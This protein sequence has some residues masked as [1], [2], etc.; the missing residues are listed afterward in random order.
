[1]AS[2]RLNPCDTPPLRTDRRK[3]PLEGRPTR[4]GR[5]RKIV[6]AVGALALSLLGAQIVLAA[7]PSASITAPSLLQIG[8]VGTFTATTSDPDGG[9][10]T[11]IEWDFEDDGTFDKTGASVSH[12]YGTAGQKTVRLRVT[13]S[14]AEVT[15]ATATVTVNAPP[16]ARI[17]AEPTRAQIGQSVAFSGID[18]S[19]PDPGDSIQTYEWDLGTGSF[20]SPSASPNAPPTSFATG[21]DKNIRLRVTDKFG[22]AHVATL[23]FHVNLKPLAKFIFAAVNPPSGQTGVALDPGQNLQVPIIGQ[24]VAF[25][26][27]STDS[28]GTIKAHAWFD[29][30]IPGEGPTGLFTGPFAGN[31]ASPIHVPYTIAGNMR[32][33]LQVT[34]NEDA[35]SETNPPT[36]EAL[37]T[38]RVNTRPESDF[39][40]SPQTPVVGETITFAQAADD[41]DP[42]SLANPPNGLV[43]KYE[44][45]LDNDGTFGEQGETGGRVQR[46]FDSAGAMPVKLRVT[47][48]A[49]A[50]HEV[51][52]TVDVA[53]TRPDARFTSSPQ[54]PL[55]GQ[56]VNFTSG[57]IPTSG[58]AITKVEWDFD[59]DQR[60]LRPTPAVRLPRTTRSVMPSP[61]M[62]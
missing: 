57:S 47:D 50:R 62:G 31:S 55:P 22:G 21:G 49:G 24:W 9:S 18:S 58:K 15:E 16:V 12:S 2:G 19:D 28:D 14:A 35:V 23:V 41:P 8:Q 40:F 60:T 44:W 13:D 54:D 20:G 43:T 52:R 6:A 56:A 26:S 3:P 32:V 45:D 53:T 29:A 46:K 25:S 42:D 39:V 4:Q 51:T 30:N 37:A 38:V 33:L 48:G 11:L 27:Q 10:I 34:D 61:A 5:Q 7:P 59:Y 17:T 1:M 36:P